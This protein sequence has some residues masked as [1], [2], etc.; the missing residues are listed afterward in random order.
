MNENESAPID[1]SQAPKWQPLGR[2]DR[3]VIGVLV[4]KAKTTP[5]QYPLSLNALRNGCNQKSNRDPVMDL[6]ED[7][8]R[9][10]LDR[11]RAAGAVAEVYGSGRVARYRH[12]M[13][14][15]LGVDAVEL[16]VMTELLLRGA[17]TEGEIRGRAARM[18]PIKD[19]AALRPALASLKAK[20]LVVPLTPEGRGHVVA[21]AVCPPQELE[22]VKQRYSG[23]RETRQQASPDEPAAAPRAMGEQP[24]HDAEIER[25]SARRLESQMSEFRDQMTQLRGEIEELVRKMDQNVDEVDRIK[26]DLGL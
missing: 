12:F 24:A 13:K 26:R 23:P 25:E 8:V 5:D 20:G 16:A 1:D 11:L 9:E 15:W 10:A 21:H 7:D 18:E 3:R 2:I 22:R 19:L 6:D 4:E 14:D 17:Q